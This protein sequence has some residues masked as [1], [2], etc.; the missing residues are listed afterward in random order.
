MACQTHSLICIKEKCWGIHYVLD[1]Q[2]EKVNGS[3]VKLHCM[4]FWKTHKDKVWF[5]KEVRRCVTCSSNFHVYKWAQIVITRTVQHQMAPR[6]WVNRWG[7]N[8]EDVG[9]SWLISFISKEMTLSQ[10]IDLL[11]DGLLHYRR[12]KVSDI[13]VALSRNTEK[14]YSVV[15]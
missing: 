1:K 2:L 9:F 3:R 11:T 14:S 6:I 7:R 4:C 13:D 8:G 10:R 12:C 15:T 5:Q